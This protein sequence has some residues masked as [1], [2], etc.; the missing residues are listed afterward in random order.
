MESYSLGGKWDLYF[1]PQ[2]ERDIK[3]PEEL[4][5]SDVPK[6]SATVP[7]NAE[8]DLARSGYLPSDL[9]MGTNIEK[10]QEYELY[11]WW[12]EREFD[13]P[14]IDKNERAF[15]KFC[16]VDCFAEYFVNG[17]LIG[18][19]NN[20][21]IEYEFEVTNAIK[22][23]KNTLCVH[24]KS[25][26]I[27]AWNKE[28]SAY[29]LANIAGGKNV[30]YSYMRRPAHSYGWDIMPRAMG[31]GIWRDVNLLIKGEIEINQ[32]Y[33]YCDVLEK[34]A[35]VY[36]T[37]DL[38]APFSKNMEV[39]VTGKCGESEFYARKKMEFK[40]GEI[41]ACID[42]P[43]LWWPYGYGK[44]N[45]YDLTVKFY[46]DGKAVAEE[47]FKTGIRSAELI[48]TEVTDG[49]NGCFKFIV[50]GEEIMVKGTNWVPMDV[51][52]SRDKER[53]Q[54]ALELLKDIGVNTVRCWGGNVYED[55]EFFD[56]CDENGIM[57]WQDFS[58]ACNMYPI[59][60]EFCEM[61]KTEAES[62]V[63]KLRNH[64]SIVLWTG[65]NECDER[66]YYSGFDTKDNRVTRKILPRVIRNN[67]V[68]RQYLASSPYI[69]SEI[70]RSGDRSRLPEEHLWG[71][72]D[73]YKSSY[74]SDSKAHFVSEIGYHGCPSPENLLK[75]IDKDHLMPSE[76]NEQWILHSTDTRGDD[77]RF[78][79][80][81]KQIK[82]LFG[83]V[84]QNIEDFA[85]ASQAAQG[86]AD[87][88]F[89]ERMRTNR[90]YKT[91]IIWWNLLDGWPQI[92]D[93]VVGYYYDKKIAYDYIKRSQM[94]F[95]LMMR[96]PENQNLTL[97]AANDTRD[98]VCG[99]FC[100]KNI[101]TDEVIKEGDFNV[102]PNRICDLLKVPVKETDKGMFLIEWYIGE[103]R[104]FNHYMYGC[105]EFDLETYKKRHSKIK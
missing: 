41:T 65:D 58:M 81:S 4:K 52:H 40:A 43:K 36:I 71:P 49:K 69:N 56:F 11:S 50:N 62:V 61:M 44:A 73:Y 29:T 31:S 59:D 18:K 74:Y 85:F 77:A 82:Q 37:Y 68:K 7:G 91:G 67:D 2:N 15:L 88:F 38:T 17:T 95:C 63:K 84:P 22:P 10:V 60:D 12:Y 96:E 26:I 99:R 5:K 42:N 86:E 53:Y 97:V 57:V 100:V 54:K 13:A 6:I 35:K 45:L 30:E 64:P 55:H 16:A 20:A 94:P 104:Y 51:F 70:C 89:I 1:Y 48:R 93:A 83:A 3:T 32:L 25:P 47:S 23:G 9:Y 66:P 46:K 8:L 76:N 98:T 24:I 21:L 33:C 75:F 78:K 87:K 39:E 105:P 72:R 28:Y 27:E 92:S 19:S 90:P 102:L 80:V 79:L 101:D 103:K 34:E 14:P